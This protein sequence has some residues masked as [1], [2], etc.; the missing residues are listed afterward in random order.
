MSAPRRQG[1]VLEPEPEPN[2]RKTAENLLDVAADE[3]Y[4]EFLGQTDEISKLFYELPHN[5]QVDFV[6]EKLQTNPA[7]AATVENFIYQA[8]L[9]E[10]KDAFSSAGHYL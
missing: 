2:H 7:L 9:Q 6:V 3:R 5:K 4:R 10:N 8:G 1:A